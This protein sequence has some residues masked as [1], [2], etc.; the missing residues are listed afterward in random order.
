MLRVKIN[1][2]RGP[3]PYAPANN[4]EPRASRAVATADTAK[5]IQNK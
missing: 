3:N 5:N 2:K 1:P 4:D